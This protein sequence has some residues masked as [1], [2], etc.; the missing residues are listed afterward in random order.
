MENS[1]QYV[2]GDANQCKREQ[3]RDGDIEQMRRMPVLERPSAENNQSQCGERQQ[4]STQVAC[5]DNG[6]TLGAHLRGD[7]RGKLSLQQP[8]KPQTCKQHGELPQGTDFLDISNQ[9]A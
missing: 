3:Q 6:S 8:G 5:A 2:N 4:E 1:A 7:A 9:I